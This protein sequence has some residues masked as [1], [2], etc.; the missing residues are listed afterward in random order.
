ML[1]LGLGIREESRGTPS[2]IWLARIFTLLVLGAVTCRLAEAAL[3]IDLTSWITPFHGEVLREQQLGRENRM[4]VN[5]AVMLLSIAFTLG[6]HVLKAPS[7]SQLTASVAIAI[8]AVS[9]TG[10]AYGLQHFYGQM[11]LLTATAGLGLACATLAMTAD[12]GGFRS[13]LSPYIGGKVARMQAL[14]GYLIPT[15]LGYILVRSAISGAGGDQSLFGV[16]VVT[17]CWFIILMISVSAFF[18]ERVDFA[19]RQAEIKLAKA[20]R[21]D[22][23]T[24]LPNRRQFFEVAQ[25]EVERTRRN[26]GQLWLVMVDLDHFKHVNDT[27]GHAMGDHVLVAVSALLSQSVRKVDLVAR[28]GGE[29]FAVLVTDTHQDG[30][31]RVAESLRQNI[32]L[33]SVPGWTDLQGPMTASLG[34]ARLGET[35]TFEEAMHAAD[36]ALYRAKK[37]GRNQVA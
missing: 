17:I 29:E 12:H 34:C 25:R 32:E 11:S 18:L 30:C 26:G 7:L 3:G 24:G 33:L 2:G 31:L 4:G 23:L 22:A 1:L 14:A 10:Y 16:F 21:T 5:S 15:A 6:L 9:F 27:A 8:P 37:A 19:R 13:M 35:E 28:I 20:A 36:E